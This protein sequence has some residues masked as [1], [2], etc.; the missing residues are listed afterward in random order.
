MSQFQGHPTP[1]HSPPSL[2]SLSLSLSVFISFLCMQPHQPVQTAER[3]SPPSRENA[4]EFGAP[5]DCEI[6]EWACGGCWGGVGGVGGKSVKN[7]PGD[8]SNRVAQTERI[9]PPT[10]SVT[11]PPASPLPPLNGTG[12]SAPLSQTQARDSG[13]AGGRKGGAPR[14]CTLHRAPSPPPLPP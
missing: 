5:S 3:D 9:A 4:S 12:R 11:T 8:P 14:S 6:S 2:F 1:Y 7:M 10:D 13:T